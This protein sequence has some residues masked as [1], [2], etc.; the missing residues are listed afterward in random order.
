[1]I[2]NKKVVL[3]KEETVAMLNDIG[4]TES[5]LSNLNLDYCAIPFSITGEDGG[6]ILVRV[7]EGLLD[8]PIVG[9][10]SNEGYEQLS[11]EECNI[12]DSET[13]D[14]M[15]DEFKRSLEYA[16]QFIQK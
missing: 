15:M 1:M 13:L 9:F 4:A 11:L 10:N 7:E 6:S 12:I 3:S 8:L 5:E 2:E 16:Q 14:S